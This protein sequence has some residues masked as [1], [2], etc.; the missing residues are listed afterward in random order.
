MAWAL[1]AELHSLAGGRSGGDSSPAGAAARVLG[2]CSGV[3]LCRSGQEAIFGLTLAEHRKSPHTCSSAPGTVAPW[4]RDVIQNVN[5][6]PEPKRDDRSVGVP[7]RPLAFLSGNLKIVKLVHGGDELVRCAEEFDTSGV[8]HLKS[9]LH[10]SKCKQQTCLRS[11]ERAA[12][13]ALSSPL[14]G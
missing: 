10:C 8:R 2:C 13:A 4:P 14:A 5:S 12:R 11:G 1:P 9:S 7:S 6:Q 3:R